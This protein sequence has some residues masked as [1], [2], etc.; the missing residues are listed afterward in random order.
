MALTI[1]WY[2]RLS[3]EDKKSHN[4]RS[5]QRALQ[6]GS[7]QKYNRSFESIYRHGEWTAKERGLEWSITKEQLKLLRSCFCYYCEGNL[8]VT[9]AGLD[10]ID[11]TKGYIFENVI[12]CCFNCNTTRMDKY[13]VD[14]MKVMM[15]ALNQYRRVP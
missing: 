10:R 5:Y 13:T 15:T 12:P 6:L 14:E 9:R 4:K 11:N 2:Q 8:P 3:Q 7:V 1:S